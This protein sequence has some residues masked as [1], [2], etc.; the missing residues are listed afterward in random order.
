MAPIL[1]QTVQGS[2]TA[3][4]LT[5]TLSATTAGN[6][7]IVK[8]ASG[9]ATT[10]AAVSGITLG[11][12]ADNFA[13]SGTVGTGA[14]TCIASIWA[15]PDCAGGQTSVVVTTTGGVGSAGV[16]CSVQEWSG[17]VASSVVDQTASQPDT[18]S[19]SWTSTA[20]AATTLPS[21]VAVGAVAVSP[22]STPTVTCTAVG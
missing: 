6:C 2:G 10:N 4:T 13:Q 7:L 15:D 5:L 9:N 11:G 22:G 21:E 1:V 17:L 8:T 19:A 14:G 20:T 3:S 18:A 12:S 16:C